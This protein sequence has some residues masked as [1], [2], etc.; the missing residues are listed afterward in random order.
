[1]CRARYDSVRHMLQSSARSICIQADCFSSAYYQTYGCAT[2]DRCQW[3]HGQGLENLNLA[4]PGDPGPHKT[5]CTVYEVA[6]VSLF[7]LQTFNT[8]NFEHVME[9]L[10]H[11]TT[12]YETL[13]ILMTFITRLC[14]CLFLLHRNICP[15]VSNLRSDPC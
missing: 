9:A 7:E 10:A 5:G 11:D 12:R 15:A 13:Y 4:N 1:M 3:V 14:T 8:S 6:S 2:Y